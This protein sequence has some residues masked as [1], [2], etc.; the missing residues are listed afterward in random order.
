MNFFA[1]FRRA[2]QHS[3]HTT[4]EQHSMIRLQL[5]QRGIHDNTVLQAMVAVPRHLFVPAPLRDRAYEDS[6]LPIEEGQTISQPFI[7]AYMAQA[8]MLTGTERVLDIGTGS[9]YAAAVMSLLA[10]EVYSVE[11][12][13]ELA[14]TARTRLAQ[15]G[16]RN[17]HVHVGDGTLGWP[18]QAPFD[19]ISVAAASPWV[20]RPLRQ[21]LALNGRMVIPVGSYD[22][23]LLVRLINRDGKIQTEQL[24]NVRFVPLVGEH[25]WTN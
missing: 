18:E 14:E 19:A 10:A 17:V 25:A 3:P 16:Y 6:A 7:V 8:L 22:Q 1:N 24:G 12:S 11:R 20:P 13:S 9:G 5:A 2:F 21:Q 15:L 4:E 23:Q